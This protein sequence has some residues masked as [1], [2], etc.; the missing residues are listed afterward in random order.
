MPLE[1]SISKSRHTQLSSVL[2]ELSL[3][4]ADFYI[5]HLVPTSGL[6]ALKDVFKIKEQKGKT[7]RKKAVRKITCG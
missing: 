5:G 6:Q 2:E 3:V 4:A 1:S 7:E